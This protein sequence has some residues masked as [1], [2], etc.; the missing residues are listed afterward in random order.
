MSLRL[1]LANELNFLIP[2]QGVNTHFPRLAYAVSDVIVLIDTV[3]FAQDAYKKKIQSFTKRATN[4]LIGDKP[5]LLIVHNQS[6]FDEGDLGD[7]EKHTNDFFMLHD[8]DHALENYFSKICCVKIPTRHPRIPEDFWSGINVFANSLCSLLSVSERARRE[9]QNLL[10]SKVW[11]SLMRD[12]ISEFHSGEFLRLG[13]MLT[14][15]VTQH[16]PDELLR[17]ALGF[18][19]SINL[20]PSREDWNVARTCATRMLAT[21]VIEQSQKG[22]ALI[23]KNDPR[24]KA[25]QEALNTKVTEFLDFVDRDKPCCAV[26]GKAVC[27]LTK[28]QHPNRHYNPAGVQ[29]T[30][31]MNRVVTKVKKILG[32]NDCHWDGG[33]VE[34]V[35]SVSNAVI[36]QQLNST[37]QQL[38]SNLANPEINRFA[39]IGARHEIWKEAFPRSLYEKI[40]GNLIKW[41]LPETCLYCMQNASETFVPRCHRTR[42][43]SCHYI[44]SNIPYHV[45]IPSILGN[46]LVS[47]AACVFCSRC[48]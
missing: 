15:A 27:V 1:K 6:G 37:V 20:G 2:I 12:V 18:Y 22:T 43:E 46:N 4:G 13:N 25:L 28:G 9:K 11:V 45:S 3:S 36:R 26:T 14:K 38:Q 48:A 7:I 47:F 41:R 40:A 42:C 16:I 8:P 24:Q 10:T 17:N 32:R 31:F 35:D 29:A 5:A 33:F 30:G 44:I 23:S 39:I 34:G 19:E 21:F